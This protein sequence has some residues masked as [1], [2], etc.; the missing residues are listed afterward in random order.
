MLIVYSRMTRVADLCRGSLDE[1]KAL[2]AT[3]MFPPGT[4]NIKSVL[5][6]TPTP[7]QGL[8]LKVLQVQSVPYI[9]ESGGGISTSCSIVGTANTSAYASTF[10]NS[11]Y[12]NATTS[13]NQQMSCDSY[14]T[15]VQWPHVLNVMFAEASDGN[16]YIFACDRAWRWSKCVP[17]Q[18]GQVFNAR[19]TEKGLEVQAFNTK[20]KEENPTYHVL[21]S[22]S[23]R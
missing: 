17:L 7:S 5:E 15:T 9:Q 6:Q 11:T 18:A 2:A 14:D 10:G 22:K 4:L 16:S 23:S 8:T 13:S 1:I 19:F 12:G 3:T 20:G 21:Q